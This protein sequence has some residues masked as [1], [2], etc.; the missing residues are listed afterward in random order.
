MLKDVD[1]SGFCLGGFPSPWK[2]SRVSHIYAELP[3]LTFAKSKFISMKIIQLTYS[4]S[5]G[6]IPPYVVGLIIE[7]CDYPLKF[8][9]I[10][11]GT[12]RN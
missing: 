7:K 4:M 8:D 1:R 10:G 3:Q 12:D 9:L 2:L 5:Q 11:H 6:T